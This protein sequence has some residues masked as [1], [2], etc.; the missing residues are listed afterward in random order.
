MSETQSGSVGP[1]LAWQFE[2]GPDSDDGVQVVFARTEARAMILAGH[3]SGGGRRDRSS[4]T[5]VEQFD[6]FI[7]ATSKQGD[8]PDV[9]DFWE[10]GYSVTC[11]EC[12]DKIS[13]YDTCY[14]CIERAAESVAEDWDGEGD[15]PVFDEDAYEEELGGPVTA[16][17]WVYCNQKCLDRE[18]ARLARQKARK[19]EATAALAASHPFVRILRASVGG[20][21][22][23]EGKPEDGFFEPTSRYE[24]D[25][26]PRKKAC[27][28]VEPDNVVVYFKV[29]GGELSETT[30]DGNAYYNAYCHRCRGMW[31]AKGDYAAFECAA[32]TP[33]AVVGAA[34]PA[35]S[36]SD[37]SATGAES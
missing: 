12:D 36:A 37:V 9:A 26:K 30:S 14:H 34:A 32:V 33:D 10:V 6:Q 27:F 8:N 23:C 35:A 22:E 31:I 28:D 15:P 2:L 17:G 24:R 3:Q 13:G 25:R 11:F 20:T 21:G 16:D 29:P 18:T 19:E 4:V 1:L 5:R 7:T